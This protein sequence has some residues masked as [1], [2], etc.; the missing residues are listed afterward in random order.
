[1]SCR[2]QGLFLSENVDDIK[3][4][5]QKQMAPM[6]KTLRKHVRID[7]ATSFLDHVHLRCTQRGC[8]P[9]ETI[10]EQYK[11]MFESRISAGATEPIAVRKTSSTNSSVVLRHGRTCSEMNWTILWTSKQKKNGATVQSFKPLFGWSSIQTGRTRVHWRVVR[12]LLANC[13]DMLVLD[14]NW[15]TWHSVVSE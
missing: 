8:K 10:I 11:K 6:S 1:M 15:A 12:S 5:G 3:M 13:L 9:N 7:E 2:K 4:A 14:M